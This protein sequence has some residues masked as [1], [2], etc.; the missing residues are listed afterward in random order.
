MRHLRRNRE[1]KKTKDRDPGQC[2]IMCQ[3]KEEEAAKETE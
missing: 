2:N 3:T 1:G